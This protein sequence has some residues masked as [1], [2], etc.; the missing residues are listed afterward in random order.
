MW[1]VTEGERDRDAVQD[2]GDTDDAS[3]PGGDDRSRVGRNARSTSPGPVVAL[4]GAA[5]V[6]LLLVVGLLLLQV[7]QQGV[8]LNLLL[9]LVEA[10]KGL[11][12]GAHQALA[13]E[14][15]RLEEAHFAPMHDSEQ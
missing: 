9:G 6:A 5:L 12:E 1:R 13:G 4:G 14:L 3:E 8:D 15:H 10:G 2:A 7:L 11:L